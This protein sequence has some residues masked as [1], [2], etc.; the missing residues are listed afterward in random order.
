LTADTGSLAVLLAAPSGL[1]LVG[2]LSVADTIAGNGL[3][4]SAP[5]VLAVNA[6]QFVATSVHV[7]TTAPLAGGGDLTANRTLA[8]TLASPSGL[9]TVGGLNVADSIAG[10]GLVMTAKVL[11]VNASL[12][13]PATR[14]LTAGA[15]LIGGGDLSADRNFAVVAGDGSL[16]V[17]ADD[18]RVNQGFAF[19]WTGNQT[20]TG[21][22]TWSTG[23]F[24]FNT[25]PKIN[26]NLDFIGGVRNITSPAATNLAVVPGGDL[27]LDPG[28]LNVLPGGSSRVDLG[29]YNRKW[30]T[31]YARELYVETLV[32]SSVMA[33]IGGRILVT[34]TTSLIADI[35]STTATTI[36]VKQNIAS[37][38]IGTYLYL[39]SAPGTPPVPQIEAMK[40]TS[41]ATAI[42]GGYRYS[43]T[44]GLNTSGAKTWLAGD[45]VVS[46]GTNVSEGYIDLASVQTVKPISPSVQKLGPTITI[47]SRSSTANWDDLV[48]TVTMGNLTSFVDYATTRFGFA[49]G[50]DLTLSPDGVNP[51]IGMTADRVNGMRLF[52][53]PLN[54]YNV[55]NAILTI[56]KI[57]GISFEFGTSLFN[58][59][60][61][62][63]D[64]GVPPAAPAAAKL[65]GVAGVARSVTTYTELDLIATAIA[66]TNPNGA[67]RLRAVNSTTAAYNLWLDSSGVYFGTGATTVSRPQTGGFITDATAYFAGNVGVGTSAP[68]ATVKL[69][70]RGAGTNT[71]IRVGYNSTNSV[72]SDWLATATAVSINAYNDA[73][74]AYVPLTLQGNP[75]IFDVGTTEYMRVDTTGNVGIGK[76]SPTAALDIYQNSSSTYA[77]SVHQAG[78]GVGTWPVLR[79]GY[80]P[81]I[82][83]LNV[84]EIVS[85][86]V[87]K[88]SFGLLNLSTSYPDMLV[89]DRGNIGIANTNP[90]ALLHVGPGVPGSG[91]YAGIVIAPNLNAASIVLRST[92]AM[93]GGMFLHSNTNAYL[94]TWTAHPLILRTNNTDRLTITV[95]GAVTIP[96]L[97]TASA[98][99]SF[100]QNTLT[101]YDESPAVWTPVITPTSGA[102]G[103]LTFTGQVGKA[104]RIGNCIFYSGALTIA[105]GYAVGTASGNARFSLP[106]AC[107]AYAMGSG[108]YNS[109]TSGITTTFTPTNGAAYGFMAATTASPQYLQC[110]ALVAGQTF[111]YGGH[112]FV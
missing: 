52:N 62:Y 34:P 17:A 108:Y 43:V 10:A 13:V 50:N 55:G 9:S 3:L 69:D 48:P 112:Y 47:Y 67:V 30:S 104:T 96:G 87:V 74:A 84:Q 53:T 111:F 102:F 18:V 86:G 12:F 110:S 7:D 14:V 36:D 15:G 39:E 45:A 91:N 25:N 29:D 19:A 26:A 61:W 41:I 35:T 56:D 103:A 57:N 2:G 58:T 46:L 54:L 24:Q 38:V 71:I 106:I 23:V 65:L 81:G 94:G 28:G 6:A 109:G 49:T 77:L 1:S 88:Y 59:I 44:R 60:G 92:L 107:V 37:F 105:A 80:N 99:I 82:Y 4:W 97:L 68:A 89:F 78:G 8:L 101:Q 64:L 85:A 83:D 76:N 5:K 16:S 98:G 63:E 33:T 100:G 40:I 72:R 20:W 32:A 70:V 75:L 11:S 95:A 31:L 27:V 93:E 66:G 22:G 79:F 21:N 51:F 42:A 73:T 90:G